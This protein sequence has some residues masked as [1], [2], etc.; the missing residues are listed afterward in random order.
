MLTLYDIY[1][2]LN[3]L[4]DIISVFPTVRVIR[5]IRVIRVSQSTEKL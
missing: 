5:V 4:C 1:V 2:E 3:V